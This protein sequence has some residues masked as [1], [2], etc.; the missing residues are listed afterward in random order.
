MIPYILR[1]TKLYKPEF[2][3]NTV[4][5]ATMNTG[6]AIPGGGA[7]GAWPPTFLQQKEKRETKG[8]KIFSKQ[9]LLKGCQQGRN[10][11][12]LA[13]LERLFFFSVPWP[14]HFEIHLTGPGIA[15]FFRGGPYKTDTLL[16]TIFFFYGLQF[17]C[18]ADV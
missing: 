10:I 8:E 13:I 5:T 6:P 1:Y 3:Q 7:R 16:K 15:S 18:N 11:T 4:K 12:V 14:L 2:L 17:C 9:K